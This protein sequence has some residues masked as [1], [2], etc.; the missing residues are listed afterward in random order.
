MKRFTVIG[1]CIILCIFMFGCASSSD[2]VIS[3][4]PDAADSVSLPTSESG[5]AVDFQNLSY[6]ELLTAFSAVKADDVKKIDFV[7]SGKNAVPYY[8]TF[9]SS[10]DISKILTT[11]FSAEIKASEPVEP[12]NG[13][14]FLI[15][16]WPKYTVSPTEIERAILIS[17]HSKEHID[18]NGNIYSVNDN[19]Y[20]AK[21]I[22]FYN[23][24]SIEEVKY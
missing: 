17:P 21:L 11:L 16:I 2:S 4:E 6:D 12:S 5:S 14:N 24:T 18:I 1:I 8:K 22:D 7:Y 15:K 20:E 23:S 10:E 19:S 13:W 9:T 3:D